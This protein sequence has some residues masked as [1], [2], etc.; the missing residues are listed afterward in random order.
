[1]HGGPWQ[2]VYCRKTDVHKEQMMLEQ[3]VRQAQYVQGSE[4][5]ARGPK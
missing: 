4:M 3:E 2:F 1:M 5:T